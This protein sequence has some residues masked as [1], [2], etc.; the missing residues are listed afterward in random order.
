MG[1][2]DGAVDHQILIVSIRRQYF[3]D[4]FPNA[5]MTQAT[6]ATLALFSIYS[7]VQAVTP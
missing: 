6:D 3:E 1:V 7:T 4:P 2:N 5:G